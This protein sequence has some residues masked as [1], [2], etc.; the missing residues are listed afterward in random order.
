MHFQTG[1]S[2]NP[3]GRPRGARNKRTLL[4]EGL[5]DADAT[6][7]INKLI[8]AAKGGDIAALRLCIDRICPPQRDRPVA[9][10]LPPM[11]SA[12]DAVAAMGAIMQAIGMGDVGAHEAA[13]L[14]KVV[15][16]FSQTITTAQLERR[17]DE[18]EKAVALLKQG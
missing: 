14:A 9:I 16:G 13:E 12:A 1:Q 3:L 5:F 10:D 4:A 8:A 6:E 2:G 7:I 11:A 18:I 17:L 15:T